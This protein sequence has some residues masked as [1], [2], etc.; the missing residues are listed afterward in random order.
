MRLNKISQLC[1]W[2]NEKGAENL[3]KQL[4][5]QSGV[6]YSAPGGTGSIVAG[7]RRCAGGEATVYDCLLYHGRTETKGCSHTIDQGVQC[8]GKQ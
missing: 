3:C 2:D 4:G 6:K 7:N 5:Y 1:R 8:S